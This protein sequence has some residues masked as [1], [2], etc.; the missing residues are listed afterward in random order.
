MKKQTTVEQIKV[1]GLTVDVTEVEIYRDYWF[2]VLKSV[3]GNS[4]YLGYVISAGPYKI[5]LEVYRRLS[6][7]QSKEYE[8]GTLD[9]ISLARQWSDED[10]QSEKF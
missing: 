6:A 3:S 8:A 2:R 4:Y 7:A 9:V 10:T 1:D 5:D